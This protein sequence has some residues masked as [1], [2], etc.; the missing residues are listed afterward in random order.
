[1]NPSR[2]FLSA[3]LA[4]CLLFSSALVPVTQ[5][6]ALP[7][8]E[9]PAAPENTGQAAETAKPTLIS[10]LMADSEQW[11]E[12]VKD[13]APSS[14]ESNRET[15]LATLKSLNALARSQFSTIA[16][17]ELGQTVVPQPQTTPGNKS[18]AGGL[19]MG[20]IGLALIGGGAYL[21]VNAKPMESVLPPSSSCIGNPP[22]CTSIP[23]SRVRLG[24][25]PA[26]RYGGVAVAGLGFWLAVAGFRQ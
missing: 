7:A 18:K 12:L 20:F 10:V 4:G 25:N 3:T 13:A 5:A 23:G 15:L 17:N 22:R 11:S 24:V 19:V 2:S 6:Q 8:R 21:A 14:P 16:M 26:M 9:T 1:M